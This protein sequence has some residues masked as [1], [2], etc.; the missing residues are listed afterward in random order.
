M[1][2]QESHRLKVQVTAPQQPDWNE[3]SFEIAG[4]IKYPRPIGICDAMEEW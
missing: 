4:L 2:G 1:F 3:L